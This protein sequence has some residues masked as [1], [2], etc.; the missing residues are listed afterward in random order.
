MSHDLHSQFLGCATRR[1]VRSPNDSEGGG[2]WAWQGSNLRPTGYAYHF[3]FCRLFRVR[4]LDCPFTH[5]LIQIRVPVYQS[6]HP[7]KLGFGIAMA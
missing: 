6:L 3:D 5:S 1:A 4:G 2:W 7:D